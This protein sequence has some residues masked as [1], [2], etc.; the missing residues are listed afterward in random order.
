MPGTLC[1]YFLHGSVA[2]FMRTPTLAVWRTGSRELHAAVINVLI[3]LS[4]KTSGY[5]VGVGSTRASMQH[6]GYE[7][8]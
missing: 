2:D 8:I 4:P 5:D 6:H 7:S 3:V 1:G